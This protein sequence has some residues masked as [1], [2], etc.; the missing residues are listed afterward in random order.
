MFSFCRLEI[1]F[2]YYNGSLHIFDLL[3]ELVFLFSI[4]SLE[5][6]M[7]LINQEPVMWFCTSAVV[8]PLIKFY[9]KLYRRK[10]AVVITLW[11]VCICNYL[12]FRFFSYGRFHMT[13]N[14][15]NRFLQY[16]LASQMTK[17]CPYSLGQKL[18]TYVVYLERIELHGLRLW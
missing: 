2:C 11:L 18:F 8:V 5:L 12:L 16:G 13:N 10:R 1:G 15:L 4:V 6:L 14:M 17:G 7:S 3:R 9:Y